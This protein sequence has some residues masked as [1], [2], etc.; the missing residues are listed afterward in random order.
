MHEIAKSKGMVPTEVK[1]IQ[2]S[3]ISPQEF[4]RDYVTKSIPLLIKAMTNDWPAHNLWSQKD[5]IKQK[6]GDISIRVERTDRLSRD[7]AYF[8]KGDKF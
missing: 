3:E 4:Y 7:F 1:R 6:A 8:K 5:Y 2:H